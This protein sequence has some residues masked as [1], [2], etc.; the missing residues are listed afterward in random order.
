[1]EQFKELDD[2]YFKS[3]NQ[4]IESMG[5][6]TQLVHT[7]DLVDVIYV[8]PLDAYITRLKNEEFSISGVSFTKFQRG[9]RTEG[10]NG[11]TTESLLSICLH[12]LARLNTNEFKCSEN[13]K[14]LECIQGALVALNARAD[15]RKKEGKLGTT[16]PDNEQ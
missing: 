2:A 4:V 6:L 13:D 3:L 5:E 14:A 7:D 10:I 9:P 15:R 16:L 12:R 11:I 8:E 1:M